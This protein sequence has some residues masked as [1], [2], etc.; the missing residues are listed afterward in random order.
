MQ[1]MRPT[2]VI[3]GNPAIKK[4]GRPIF[5]RGGRPFLGKS[6]RLHTA[7]EAAVWELK[8]QMRSYAQFPIKGPIQIKFLFFRKDKRAV[9]LSNLYEFPQDCLQ[10]VGVIENDAQ[11]Q[12]HDGSR[13]GYD[14]GNPRTEIFI[15]QMPLT[16]NG[17]NDNNV[18]L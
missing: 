4:N 2:F 16:P 13:K 7:E 17:H 8:S 11:I 15:S 18:S 9:D 3:T 1:A 5:V 6:D 12:S 14:P 10:S